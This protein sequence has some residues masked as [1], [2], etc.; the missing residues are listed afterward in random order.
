MMAAERKPSVKAGSTDGLIFRRART[1]AAGDSDGVL[2]FEDGSSTKTIYGEPLLNAAD[3][4]LVR[5]VLTRWPQLAWAVHLSAVLGLVP[6]AG[7]AAITRRY[8]QQL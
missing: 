2:R 3:A 7:L 6:L 4:W 1:P 5:N 8:T